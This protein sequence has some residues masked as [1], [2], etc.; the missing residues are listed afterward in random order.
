MRQSFELMGL[1]F[2]LKCFL[3]ELI[4]ALYIFILNSLNDEGGLINMEMG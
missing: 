4:V 3:K 1:A 2:G